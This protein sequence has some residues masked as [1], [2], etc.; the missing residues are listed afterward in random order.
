MQT[1]RRR[2]YNLTEIQNCW[3]PWTE[4]TTERSQPVVSKILRGRKYDHS[5]NQMWTSTEK[6]I[7]RAQQRH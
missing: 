1:Q 7:G 2:Y 4:I 5:A 6:V 3:T